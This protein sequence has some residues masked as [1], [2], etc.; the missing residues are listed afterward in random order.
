MTEQNDFTDVA[1]LQVKVDEFPRIIDKG[2]KAKAKT[3]KRL[4]QA[5]LAGKQEELEAVKKEKREEYEASK[6]D[7]TKK[8]VIYDDA[9]QAQKDGLAGLRSMKEAIAEN[10][11]QFDEA[12]A[13][14]TRKFIEEESE[15]LR[16]EEAAAKK[17]EEEE[18]A[19]NAPRLNNLVKENMIKIKTSAAQQGVT[20]ID[21][22][23]EPQESEKLRQE[24]A[25]VTPETV[26]ISEADVTHESID[27]VPSSEPD[28]AAVVQEPSSEPVA[29][30]APDLDFA[31]SAV[32]EAARIGLF[33]LLHEKTVLGPDRWLNNR[34]ARVQ[35]LLDHAGVTH[36]KEELNA[37][38]ERGV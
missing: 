28:T 9:V 8:K 11:K 26:I 38:S 22:E 30:P 34:I 16:Q 4:V 7:T 19:E 17:K 31:D 12:V 5:L 35:Q 36:T 23:P 20:I 25:D 33:W 32:I 6:I 13:E 3:L 24:E 37:T 14:A 2:Q 10:I 1:A 29:Q 21:I 15:K 18:A 27:L